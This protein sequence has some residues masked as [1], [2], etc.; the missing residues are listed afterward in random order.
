MMNGLEINGAI[1]WLIA[2]VWCSCAKLTS[3]DVSYHITYVF[4]C[5]AAI[6]ATND[7]PFHWYS[8]NNNTW[9]WYDWLARGSHVILWIMYRSIVRVLASVFGFL[10]KRLRVQCN[11]NAGLAIQAI[12]LV[13]LLINL[14]SSVRKKSSFARISHSQCHLQSQS[15]IKKEMMECTKWHKSPLAVHVHVLH[16]GSC[17]NGEWDDQTI[18]S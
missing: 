12:I 18:T 10:A 11:H 6:P 14:C 16:N 17:N 1:N 9:V 2:G 15:A 13:L 3:N 7:I 8:L 4:S 5:S